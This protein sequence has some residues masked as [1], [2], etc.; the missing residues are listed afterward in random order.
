MAGQEGK[1]KNGVIAKV[2]MVLVVLVGVAVAWIGRTWDPQEGIMLNIGILVQHQFMPPVLNIL[3]RPLEEQV[4]FL[5]Q[6]TKRIEGGNS[7]SGLRASSSPEFANASFGPNATRVAHLN[8]PSSKETGHLI[9]VTCTC[10]PNVGFEDTNWPLILYLHA[11]GMIIGSVQSELPLARYLAVRVNAVVCSIE[12][13]LA[14]QYA[15]PAAIDDALDASLALLSDQGRL[16]ANALQI[17]LLGAN[18]NKIG[19]FGMS[20]GG[21]MAAHTARLLTHAGQQVAC[22]ISQV[23]MAK[24][25]GGTDSILKRWNAPFWSSPYNAYA[26][27]VYLKG[28]DGSLTQDWKVSLLVDPPPETLERLPQTYIQIATKDILHDE[29]KMYAERLESQG[30]LIR[31]DEYDTYHVGITPPMSKGGPGENATERVIQVFIE[32]LS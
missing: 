24:P 32:H 8:I 10:P 4:E 26:W 16:V 19:T 30:K 1:K 6:I 7:E 28:D 20:A 12:Y 2:G 27:S 11:G 3:D 23:P 22:Q 21:F 15:Y 13:R 17:G 29:G 14:P 5:S 25:H 31:L 9:P 18:N